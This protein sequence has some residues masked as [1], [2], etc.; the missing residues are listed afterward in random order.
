MP[1]ADSISV[2]LLCDLMIPPEISAAIRT[3]DYDVLEARTLLPEIQQDDWAIL[4]E[5]S[6]QRRTVITCNYSDPASNFCLIHNEWL[7]QSQTHFGIILI[8]QFQISS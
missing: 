8:P 5:A 3:Q 7:K 1:D 2:R 6:S 4:A